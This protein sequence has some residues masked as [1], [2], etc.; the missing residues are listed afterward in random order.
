MIW[1]L[2]NIISPHGFGAGNFKSLFEAIEADQ[3]QVAVVQFMEPTATSLVL[4]IWG[5]KEGEMSDSGCLGYRVQIDATQEV[6]VP[7]V[8]TIPLLQHDHSKM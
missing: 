1:D 2:I 5:V 8:K 3:I 7:A 6:P 4:D